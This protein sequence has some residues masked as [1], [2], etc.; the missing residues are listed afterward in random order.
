M[1]FEPRDVK[2]VTGDK[3]L[4]YTF[5]LRL[6]N[7]LDK[8]LKAKI[9]IDPE[10]GLKSF[11]SAPS[12]TARVELAAGEEKIVPIRLF[13]AAQDAKN[14]APA[15]GER[16]CPR[17]FAE[18]IEDS[19]VQPLEGYRNMYLWAVVPVKK[20]PRTPQTLQARVA[21]S[22]KFMQ[23][24]DWKSGILRRADAALKYDWPA[25][26]WLTPGMKPTATPFWGQSYRCPDCKDPT[27]QSDPPNEIKRHVCPRCKKVIENDPYFDQCMRQEYFRHRFADIRAWPWPG[28]SR[29]TRNTRT[30]RCDHA[31]L[32]GR[33]P[34][35]DRGRLPLDRR[36]LQAGE[37]HPG[38]DLV[39]AGFRRGLF[40]ARR[41]S[42]ARRR[43]TEED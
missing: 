33:L 37:E 31:R 39:P 22:A 6:K 9:E 20:E 2:I 19:D 17:V 34:E 41:L 43:E 42:R 5:P 30:R 3:E 23:V 29:A 11:K 35:D 25:F 12:G 32:R 21:E 8:P 13:L 1:D 14:L 4:A 26:D 16:I 18:G 38:R 36:Q 40:A 15:Y 28:C 7:R 10:K 27:L 24:D